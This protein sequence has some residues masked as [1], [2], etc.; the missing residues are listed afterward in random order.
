MNWCIRILNPSGDPKMIPLNRCH[1][2]P[3]RD[4]SVA[5]SQIA[6][7]ITRDANEKPYL[8]VEAPL[9]NAP[10]MTVGGIRVAQA[11]IPAETPVQIGESTVSIEPVSLDTSRPPLPAGYRGVEWKTLS[12][13]GAEMLWTIRKS[14]STS[15]AIYLEGETGT[16]K[17]VLARLIHGWSERASG[18]FV[19]LNCGAL[20]SS[21]A[22]SELFGHAKGA[23]TGAISHR[24]GALMQAHGGTLFLD[25]VADLPQDVQVKLLRFLEDGEVRSV[26][27]DRITHSQ[28]RIICATH[29]PLLSLVQSGRFRKD[30]YFRLASIPIQIPPLR[31]RPED[32]GLLAREFASAQQKQLTPDALNRL[33]AH[34][35]PGNVRELRH[36]IERASGMV[37]PFNNLLC[38]E[39]FDFLIS[40]SAIEASP[41]LAIEAPILSL[42]EME[43]LMLL[44]ALRLCNGHRTE[45]AK[46]LGIA[47][48]T[49][50]EMIKRHRIQGP[51]SKINPLEIL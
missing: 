43:R 19:A 39:H 14:A 36:S 29:K 6:F 47:R 13:S 45:A 1:E 18:P 46:L 49:L 5:Q 11:L 10:T 15:L 50:F 28:V 16:G 25:E 27:S 41:E 35:W 2:L 26:G 30:L 38:K 48:S 12:R 7:S 31:E 33:K 37:G 51:R 9:M 32:I 8:K 42:H 44:R 3:L 20:P 22:E 21:L 17:E 40:P 34:R 23:F 24:S 4:L